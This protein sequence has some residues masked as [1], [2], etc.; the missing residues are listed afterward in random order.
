L[1]RYVSSLEEKL[2]NQE[3]YAE[4]IVGKANKIKEF[5]DEI[6]ELIMDRI[7]SEIQ[8]FF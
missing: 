6:Q 1:P 3:S 8:S 2:K 7:I 4:A 5:K